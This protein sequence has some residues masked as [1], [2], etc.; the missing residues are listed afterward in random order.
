[1]AVCFVA[2]IP[3]REAAS[4]DG[5]PI[6]VREIE[7]E[8]PEH[9]SLI[10]GQAHL[11]KAVEDLY[12]PL[13]I[14]VPRIQFGVTFCEASGPRLVRAEGTDPGLRALA[15]KNAIAIRAGYSFLVM[16]QRLCAQRAPRDPR[17]ARGVHRLLRTP[18]IRSRSS[19]RRARGG[20][21]VVGVIDG[22]RRRDRVRSGRVGA[23]RVRAAPRIQAPLT[24]RV[25]GGLSIGSDTRT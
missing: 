16:I 14:S 9:M 20:R 5:E 10:V 6:D 2:E 7:V 4:L 3:S 8:N 15:A 18:P 13:A 24:D 21:G 19:W 11:I 22:K 25:G 1:L 12:E 23:A 17:G